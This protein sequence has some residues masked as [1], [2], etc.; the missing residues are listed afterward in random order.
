MTGPYAAQSTVCTMAARGAEY[1]GVG[2]DVAGAKSDSDLPMDFMA[3]F[4]ALAGAELPSDA[5]PDSLSDV[6]GWLGKASAVRRE[7]IV[8][9]VSHTKVMRDG[10]W[11][12][13]PPHEGDFRNEE[14]NVELGKLPESQLYDLDADLGQVRNIAKD[15]P[16]KVT[17]MQ[18]QMDHIIAVPGTRPGYTAE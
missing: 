17:A 16:E 11:S 14:K 2:R 10:A 15:K 9:G 13:I 1:S 12:M 7:L 5:G 3:T 18:Q 6:D 4:A 8:E